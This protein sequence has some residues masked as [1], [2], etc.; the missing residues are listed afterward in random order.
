MGVWSFDAMKTMTMGDG[1]ALWLK[2]AELRDR[3][4]T[5]RYLGLGQTS[6]LNVLKNG[7]SRWWEY[8][9]SEPSGRCLCY[10]ILAAIG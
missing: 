4:K 2:D 7:R 5:L 1:G 3:A 6:G 9:V 8:S 10:E